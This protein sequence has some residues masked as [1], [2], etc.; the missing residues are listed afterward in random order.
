MGTRIW[1]GP[2]GAEPIGRSADGTPI[3]ANADG[4]GE[5]VEITGIR[6]ITFDADSP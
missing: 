3:L 5:M 2:E 6:N 4:V 1:F